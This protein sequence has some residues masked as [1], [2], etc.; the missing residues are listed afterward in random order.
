M[1]FLTTLTINLFGQ[2]QEID[3]DMVAVFKDVSCS[4]EFIETMNYYLS[5]ESLEEIDKKDLL[6]FTKLCRCVNKKNISIYE[7]RSNSKG[8]DFYFKKGRVVYSFSLVKKNDLYY[9]H[10]KC[11]T[12][13]NKR[14]K[15]QGNMTFKA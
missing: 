13:K 10:G 11:Y 7:I 15:K 3:P 9:S 1:I 6:K 12:F 4:C 8:M 5:A 14:I 2:T